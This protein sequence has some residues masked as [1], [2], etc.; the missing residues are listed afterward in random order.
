MRR[1]LGVI[2]ALIFV[3]GCSASGRPSSGGP[4]TTPPASTAVTATRAADTRATCSPEAVRS[5]VQN[6]LS[7]YNA[8]SADITDR[9]IAPRSDFMWFS[10]P[11][12]PF[13]DP[14]GVATDRS[15]LPA[16]FQKRHQLGDHFVLTGLQVFGSDSH[17]DRDFATRLVLSG[18]TSAPV[19]YAGKGAVTCD[20]GKLTLWLINPV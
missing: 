14:D 11:G 3:V 17:G 20:T 12:R 7:A 9:F 13:P 8:G 15:T 6:F 5:L 1:R 10:A 16:Y 18:S 19:H 4:A 2:G